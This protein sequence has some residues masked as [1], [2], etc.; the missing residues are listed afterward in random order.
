M[1]TGK[2]FEFVPLKAWGRPVILD[3]TRIERQ[4]TP[5]RNAPRCTIHYLRGSQGGEDVA[6]P[7]SQSRR[8]TG[9]CP[10]GTQRH[11]AIR[12]FSGGTV[13]L[14]LALPQMPQGGE[15]NRSR[16]VDVGWKPST[17]ANPQTSVNEHHMYSGGRWPV[18]T[19]GPSHDKP[20]F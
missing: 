11:P 5:N 7:A 4:N 1:D 2:G 17:F 9:D 15:N 12:E 19:S 3:E 13:A 6:N 16:H 8:S 18:L 10:L 14:A 20:Q